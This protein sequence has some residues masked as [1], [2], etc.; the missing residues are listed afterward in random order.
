MRRS[1]ITLALLLVASACGDAGSE[2]AGAGAGG[3]GGGGGTTTGTTGSGGQT[4]TTTTTATSGDDLGRP[5]ALD[6]DC[7][8][9]FRCAS[10]LADE[11]TF[12]GGP[13]GGYCTKSCS[14]STECPGTTSACYH[15]DNS[16][17][18]VCVLGCELG[19]ALAALDDP[20]L[21]S[22]CHER[23]DLR[24]ASFD[25][26]AACIPT[27]GADAQC[28]TGRHC[29]PQWSV[30]VDVPTQGKSAGDPCDPANAGE[31]AG[32]CVQ[33]TGTDPPVAFCSSFCALGGDIT[34]TFDCGGLEYGLCAFAP[35]TGSG[36]G[37][38]GLCAEICQ[39]HTD[40]QLPT[41]ACRAIDGLTGTLVDGGYCLFTQPCTKLGE[42]CGTQGGP[43]GLLCTDTP[44]GPLCLD[45]TFPF[46]AQGGGGAGSGG[47]GG[48]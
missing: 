17:D 32:V 16:P 18:G 43:A 37:D 34:Q 23:D 22:K 21:A 19:P 14:S 13:A 20:L 28:P 41:F 15:A 2:P 7:A 26:L 36:P 39:A 10:A 3:T 31:C 9:G 25:K 5:C 29:D 6:A 33:V 24:C 38:A 4:A 42:D 35:S 45:E 40:C 27:C 11:P 12:H 44:N 8:G 47:G 48:N 30:C 1:C 46:D